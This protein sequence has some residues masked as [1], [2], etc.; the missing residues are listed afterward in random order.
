MCSLCFG[1][2]LQRKVGSNTKSH[3][4]EQGVSQLQRPAQ[5]HL[6]E[7]LANGKI[8]EYVHALT[9]RCWLSVL[10]LRCSPP[11]EGRLLSSRVVSRY[12]GHLE[13]RLV[14]CRLPARLQ[15]HLLAQ[16]LLPD[17]HHGG[18]GGLDL[19]AIVPSPRRL[20]RPG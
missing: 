19:L 17:V 5:E 16:Q 8:F 18:H 14:S 20:P 4:A 10:F 12:V 7:A 2:R 3:P 13:Q 15:L 6:I 1:C 11:R 9:F